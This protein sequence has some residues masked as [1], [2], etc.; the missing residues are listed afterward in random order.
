MFAARVDD[1]MKSTGSTKKSTGVATTSLYSIMQMI[2]INGE[3][4]VRG[5]DRRDERA[6]KQGIWGVAEHWR[7]RRRFFYSVTLSNIQ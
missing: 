2:R 1:A 3:S 6:W 5:D 4:G 7:E